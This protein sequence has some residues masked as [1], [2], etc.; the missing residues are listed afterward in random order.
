VTT[1]NKTW[2]TTGGEHRELSTNLAHED[3]KAAA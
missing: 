3:A 1:M 2:L